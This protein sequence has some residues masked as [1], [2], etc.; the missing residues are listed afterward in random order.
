MAILKSSTF[1]EIYPEIIREI[2]TD[3]WI[4]QPFETD[5]HP[6]PESFKKYRAIWD[7]GATGCVVSQKVLDELQLP[8]IGKKWVIGVTGEAEERDEYLMG[9][10]L[11][12]SLFRGDIDVII[13]NTGQFTDV[14]I[15]MNII[16]DG[17]FA[18]THQNGKSKFTF[19][20]P[21]VVDIDFMSNP[22]FTQATKK[23]SRNGPCPC[24]SGKKFKHCCD[25][26]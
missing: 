26:K 25:R 7:T 2:S 22:P 13:G 11:P 3:V 9:I 8:W 14:L 21:S 10:R 19:Q 1:T 5:Y 15:G 17:D 20:I 18:L 23:V 16:A 12:N 4:A 24:G 6:E